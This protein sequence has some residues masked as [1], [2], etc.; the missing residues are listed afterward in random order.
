MLVLTRKPGEAI[1]VGDNIQVKVISVDGDQ[2]KIGIEAPQSLKIYRHELYE[3]I[4]QENKEALYT[5][6]IDILNDWH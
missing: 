4:Q 6:N 1:V 3:A 2:V 5:K